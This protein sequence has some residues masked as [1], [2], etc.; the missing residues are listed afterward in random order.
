M[1]ASTETTPTRRDGQSHSI[2]RRISGHVIAESFFLY[3][4]SFS[5]ALCLGVRNN[6]T[7]YYMSAHGQR[8][9]FNKSEMYSM[10]YWVTQPHQEGS[11]NVLWLV[12]ICCSTNLIELPIL[13]LKA[14]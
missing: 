11:V 2:K 7:S 1:K 12:D 13:S 3:Q 8:K 14:G 5:T 9:L 10:M 4:S 6:V